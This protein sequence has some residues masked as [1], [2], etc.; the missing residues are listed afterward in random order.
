MEVQTLSITKEVTTLWDKA[1]EYPSFRA[2]LRILRVATA[3]GISAFL[4]TLLPQLQAEPTI[5]GI[6]LIA[7][8]L[9]YVDKYLRDKKVY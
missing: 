2:F 7:L 6:P 9:L 5:G 4:A 1:L 8:L 3:A